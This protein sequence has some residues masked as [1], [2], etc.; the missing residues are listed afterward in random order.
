MG[1]NDLNQ[2]SLNEAFAKSGMTSSRMTDHVALVMVVLR[3]SEDGILGTHFRK[4][5]YLFWD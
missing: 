4:P 5:K 3:D 2:K 1:P